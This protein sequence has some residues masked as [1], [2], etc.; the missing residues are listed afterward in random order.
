M[1]QFDA[2]KVNWDLLVPFVIIFFLMRLELPHRLLRGL[3][4]F[5]PSSQKVYLLREVPPATDIH[6]EA[7]TTFRPLEHSLLQL[8]MTMQ[9]QHMVSQLPFYAFYKIVVLAGF[10]TVLVHVWYESY[11][12]LVPTAA[13]VSW[14]LFLAV[15]LLMLALQ[16]QMNILLMTGLKAFESQASFYSGL[17]MIGV[18]FVVLNVFHEF[19]GFRITQTVDD[20]AVHVNV[21]L[22]QV[23]ARPVEMPHLVLAQLLRAAVASIF[24]IITASLIVPILRFSQVL[25]AVLYGVESKNTPWPTKLLLLLDL[26]GPFVLAILFCPLTWT[27]LSSLLP[28]TILE[29]HFLCLHLNEQSCRDASAIIA[30]ISQIVQLASVAVLVVVRFQVLKPYLQLMLDTTVRMVVAVI[31]FRAVNDTNKPLLQQRLKVRMCLIL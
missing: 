19:M 4:Y 31:K 10:A 20:M 1:V 6:R 3:R 28:E 12:C 26:C 25:I 7:V 23:S 30:P 15:G 2:T 16:C 8:D 9:K 13:H 29:H 22:R 24:G 18:S 5:I 11:H 14:G 17:L 27:L 21:L